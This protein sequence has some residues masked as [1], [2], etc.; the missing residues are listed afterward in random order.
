MLVLAGAL[1]PAQAQFVTSEGGVDFSR[2]NGF[3]GDTSHLQEGGLDRKN[4]GTADRIPKWVPAPAFIPRNSTTEWDYA[5]N[6]YISR[7]G[8]IGSQFWAPVD[9]P[10]GS[11]LATFRVFYYDNS[12]SDITV[13]LTYYE[14]DTAP[15]NFDVDNFTS[16]GTPGFASDFIN[17]FHTIN[18]Y[19][20]GDLTLERNYTIIASLPD[21]SNDLRLKGVR[22]WWERQS[23]PAPATA[24]FSDVGTGHIFFKPIEALADAGITGGCGGG[25]FCPNNTVTRGQMAAFLSRA[26]GLHWAVP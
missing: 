9:L 24:T 25:N 11:E 26:L 10:H 13:W 1:S 4:F 19:P 16:S 5:G 6:G 15:T 12:A 7:D 2:D 17:L 18:N 21:A 14:G 22:L 3:T 8:G 20:N 23:S